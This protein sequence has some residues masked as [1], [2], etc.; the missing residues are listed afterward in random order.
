MLSRG[1]GKRRF[2]R[3]P[4]GIASIDGPRGRI[5][6]ALG[7]GPELKVVVGV[8]LAIV[9]V[10][11]AC[12]CVE[13]SIHKVHAYTL[14]GFRIQVSTR[15]ERDKGPRTCFLSLAILF[16]SSASLSCP[17]VL[18]VCLYNQAGPSG[19]PSRIRPRVQ[20]S[21]SLSSI[22]KQACMATGPKG[23]G[24]CTAHTHRAAAAKLS[25]VSRPNRAPRGE[26]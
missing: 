2:V 3:P 12:R 13:T 15:R 22:R 6:G 16:L 24:P 9:D 11:G 7:E 14:P 4:A 23:R 21:L 17:H 25:V 18:C 1:P 19:R 20:S 5:Y 8:A 10:A 26:R